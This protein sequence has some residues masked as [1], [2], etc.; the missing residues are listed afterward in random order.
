MMMCIFFLF[1]E[2]SSN[3]VFF[4]PLTLS[5]FPKEHERGRCIHCPVLSHVLIPLPQTP[6]PQLFSWP[7]VQDVRFKYPMTSIPLAHL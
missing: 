7:S 6:S 2:L 4:F 5:P 3:Q 1:I